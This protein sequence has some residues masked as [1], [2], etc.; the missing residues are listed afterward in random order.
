M[1]GA[2]NEEQQVACREVQS[3]RKKGILEVDGHLYYFEK[4]SKCK[5]S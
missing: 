5:S 1:E 4:T 3:Q 2:D